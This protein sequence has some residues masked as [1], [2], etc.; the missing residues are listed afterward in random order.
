MTDERLLLRLQRR[1]PEALEDL[2]ERYN[3]LVYITISNVLGRTGTQGDVEE[4]VSDTFLAVWN[5]AENIQGTKLKAYLCTTGRNKAK[6][7]LRSRKTL[8]MDLDEVDLVTST[9]SPEEAVMQKDLQNQVKKAIHKMRPKDREIFLRYYYYL[10]TA[11]EIGER[12]NIPS[13]TVRSRLIRGR[14]ILQ[15]S[16]NK[17]VLF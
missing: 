7:F 9:D 11:E 10:Q 3:K 13:S 8:P 6:S 17:E 4:L 15:K 16:L 2:M 12:M 5:Y 1:E 14:K